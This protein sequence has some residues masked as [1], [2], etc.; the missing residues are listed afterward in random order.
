MSLRGVR[1][2]AFPYTFSEG[3]YQHTVL[4]VVAESAGI[5]MEHRVL[6][7]SGLRSR[8]SVAREPDVMREVAQ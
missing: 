5:P 4:G 3:D 2:R 8:W 6:R 7:S 1:L